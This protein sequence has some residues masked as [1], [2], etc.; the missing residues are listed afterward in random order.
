MNELAFIRF[1][2]Q[3]HTKR[4][5]MCRPDSDILVAR[6]K[7]APFLP[8]GAGQ[9]QHWCRVGTGMNRT[10]LST[11]QLLVRTCCKGGPQNALVWVQAVHVG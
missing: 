11:V 7:F 8:T 9:V 10:K 2:P 4:Q 6:T 1:C 5:Q 3:I